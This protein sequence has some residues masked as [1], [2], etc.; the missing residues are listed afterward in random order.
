MSNLFLF[1]QHLNKKE[2]AKKSDYFGLPPFYR[3]FLYYLPLWRFLETA[4]QRSLL[5][6]PCHVRIAGLEPAR[7]TPPHFECGVSAFHHT[8][9]EGVGFEPTN[10]TLN[11]LRNRAALRSFDQLGYPS[12]YILIIAQIFEI[13][14][15]FLKKTFS[16][17]QFGFA[18]E[19]PI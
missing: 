18:T 9:I 1:V 7:I 4:R 11:C 6:L 12:P 19:E 10:I 16:S 3:R 14:K 2:G 5:A 8:R 17:L 13:V 15:F